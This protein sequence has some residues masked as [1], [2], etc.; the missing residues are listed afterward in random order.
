M[1][2]LYIDQGPGA[3]EN[4]FV[5][6]HLADKWLNQDSTDFRTDFSACPL[7]HLPRDEKKY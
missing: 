6:D 3:Q 5:Q 4:E 1:P 7:F 2:T